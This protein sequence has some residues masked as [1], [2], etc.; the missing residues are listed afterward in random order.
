MKIQKTSE[1]FT[2]G[3]IMFPSPNTSYMEANTQ[4]GRKTEKKGPKRTHMCL[5]HGLFY[6]HMNLG[7][8]VCALCTD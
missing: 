8:E 5:G 2:E 6:T 1:D 3:E 7:H 4:K